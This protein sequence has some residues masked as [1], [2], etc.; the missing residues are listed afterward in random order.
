MSHDL[1]PVPTLFEWMG[2]MPALRKLMEVFYRRV[3][4]DPLL[5]PLFARMG[6]D[7]VD[8][9]AR[10]VAEVFGGPKTYSASLAVTRR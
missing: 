7:H 5:A 6:P 3:P 1:K 2:G 9:V 8:H 4:E 10:F